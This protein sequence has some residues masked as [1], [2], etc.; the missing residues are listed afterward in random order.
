MGADTFAASEFD[1]YTITQPKIFQNGDVLIGAC[2]YPRW[3]QFLKYSAFPKYKGEDP[4]FY[5]AIL[6][7]VLLKRAADCGWQR[8]TE[9]GIA[10]GCPTLMGING[11]LF[12][13]QD[14]MDALE[15]ADGYMAVG[16]GSPFALGVLH[17]TAEED[18]VAPLEATDRLTLALEAAAHFTPN[19][20]APF[21]FATLE[22]HGRKAK[23]R[24]RRN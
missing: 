14:T 2:G 7:Q 23:A 12:V 10:I 9:D 1:G 20:R 11:R 24:G 15:S 5:M 17:A 13:M 3:A 16:S 21:L 22:K 19:V 8:H 18:G 6:A 4:D